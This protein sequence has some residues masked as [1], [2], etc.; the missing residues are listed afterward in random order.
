MADWNSTADPFELPAIAGSSLLESVVVTVG[1]CGVVVG[2]ASTRGSLGRSRPTSPE[3]AGAAPASA[4]RTPGPPGRE[5]RPTVLSAGRRADRR[6]GGEAEQLRGLGQDPGQLLLG[7]LLFAVQG[8]EHLQAGG[9]PGH[10]PLAHLEPPLRRGDVGG[11]RRR[12]LGAALDRLPLGG[13]ELLAQRPAVGGH[14]K[15]HRFR[16]LHSWLDYALELGVS[17]LALGPIFASETHGYDTT[18][19]VRIDPRLGDDADFDA[20]VDA[21]AGRG[22]RIMLDGVFNHVTAPTSGVSPGAGRGTR[23][24]YGVMVPAALAPDASAW[25][26]GTLP[27][28][29]DFEGHHHVV[30]LDHSSPAVVDHVAAV[31]NHWLDRGAAAWRLDA[32]YAVPTQFWAQVADRGHS[33]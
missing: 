20:L 11:G 2:R 28:Y 31:M 26:P 15:R 25:H 24:R 10:Q 22:L 21:A 16:H 17:G 13:L 19:H 14:P 8:V 12:R 9:Q 32:A 4:A 1:D 7:S 5:R 3:I 30:A 27:D 6:G 18:D 29:D 23:C 33:R